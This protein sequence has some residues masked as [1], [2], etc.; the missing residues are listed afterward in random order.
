MSKSPRAQKY[1]EE[2]RRLR[3]KAKAAAASA[4]ILREDL[5]RIA[6]KYEMLADIIER[7]PGEH[8]RVRQTL[9]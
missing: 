2:A 1:R 4:S 6:H 9:H 7:P 3:Q 5:R 8:R